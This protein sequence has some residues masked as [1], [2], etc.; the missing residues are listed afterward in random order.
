MPRCRRLPGSSV[1]TDVQVWTNLL[2]GLRAPHILL[3]LLL[4]A[5]ASWA[6][7][8]GPSGAVYLR[9]CT[10]IP[11]APERPSAADM[12]RNP[13][14]LVR[15]HGPV[16]DADR[17]AVEACGAR[18]LA[19]I[20][21]YT[22][23]AKLDPQSVDRLL[24][25]PQV[26]W[27]GPYIPDYKVSPTLQHASDSGTFWVKLFTGEAPDR[28]VNAARRSGLDVLHV[29]RDLVVLRG[30]SHAVLSLASLPAVE[31]MEPAPH[32]TVLNDRA[33]GI[34]RAEAVWKDYGLYG[35]GQVVAVTDTGLSDGD[36]A[37]VHPDLRGRIRAAI[38]VT[39]PDDWG[40]DHG[41]GTHVAGTIAGSGLLSG[42]DPQNRQFDGSFA[43]VA[44]EAE[45]VIQAVKAGPVWM[46]ELGLPDQ[47]GDLLSQAYELGARI[48]NN[49]W[50]D[51]DAGYGEYNL[52]ARQ[53]DEFAWGHPDMLT[54]FAAGNDGVEDP[55]VGVDASKLM[56]PGTVLAPGTAKNCLTVGATEN[57]RPPS[58]NWAGYSQ[59]T[60]SA[61]GFETEPVASDYVSDNP[62]GIAAFSGR[63]PT[64]DGRIKPDLVAPGTDI[65][66]TRSLRAGPA[67]YWSIYDENY[68]YLGGT[69][70]ACAVVSGAA[71]IVRQY[72]TE[73]RG[74]SAPSAALVKA[75]LLAAGEDISPG[76]YNDGRAREVGPRPDGAQGWGRLN[77]E[78][79]LAGR[80]AAPQ[81]QF[82]DV[83]NGLRTGERREYRIRVE[84]GANHL[85]A[86][87]V[88]SD[89]PG[90]PEAARAL[91]ND[92]DLL[93][94][95]PDG[96]ALKGNGREDRRNN[97]EVVVI[98]NPR[99]GV[100]RL[101]V[102]GHNVPFG[103][104]PFALVVLGTA[105]PLELL[106]DIDGNGRVEIADV[107][108]GLRIVTGAVPP[109]PK[110]RPASAGLSSSTSAP[111]TLADVL[112]AL[113]IAV[114]AA[115]G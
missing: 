108:L 114:G 19:Y 33:R 90:A 53:V 102:V 98:P 78:A 38:G 77:L 86:A 47:I 54:V 59:L 60:W 26:A 107:L 96:R 36:L 35:K 50:G 51:T 39:R 41:H 87:L 17:Q 52:H 95:A 23:L 109:L 69:S 97:V 113:R 79:A 29:G 112:Q 71:A 28:V 22:F 1:G 93:V 81:L 64:Q 61:L 46:E 32:P 16:H 89:A 110:Q 30:S 111:L 15:L 37:S 12:A 67:R 83:T 92:L 103:P 4:A 18:I 65:I 58:E 105:E 3:C 63:G 101:S 7:T 76:Q 43:G 21:D 49:S 31:W 68:A 13:Y 44:P 104:Q 115:V 14:Y 75:V 9:A 80:H 88:W 84:H 25:L 62:A 66:S 94:I 5:S 24:A 106:G 72:L 57:D 2:R 99:D 42:A 73:V 82:A 40:D 70:M 34:V 74:A 91:V 55:E 20:P 85:T 8:N 10:V 6:T 48:H 27:L 100:Y 56:A 11:G 45:L